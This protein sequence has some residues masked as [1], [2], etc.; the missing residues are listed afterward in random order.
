MINYADCVV[1]GLNNAF[2][3][4]DINNGSTFAASTI[5]QTV[6]EVISHKQAETFQKNLKPDSYVTLW[7]FF[8]KY[9]TSVILVSVFFL[10]AIVLIIITLLYRKKNKYEIEEQLATRYI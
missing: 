4:T 7:N 2:L 3:T 6:S 8:T 10:L 5:N 9:K 1:G